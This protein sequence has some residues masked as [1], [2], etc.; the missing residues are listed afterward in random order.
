MLWN[1]LIGGDEF[2]VLG[3]GDIVGIL[4]VDFC[5]MCKLFLVI[6]SISI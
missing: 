1:D 5:S 4:V 3:L 2:L 6:A